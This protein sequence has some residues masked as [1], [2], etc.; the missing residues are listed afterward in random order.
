MQMDVWKCILFDE[1]HCLLSVIFCNQKQLVSNLCLIQVI[2]HEVHY[3]VMV[4]VIVRVS[5][6]LMV[7][8]MFIVLPVEGY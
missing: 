6:M 1:P 5:V 3:V 8:V 2:A 4:M 7:N